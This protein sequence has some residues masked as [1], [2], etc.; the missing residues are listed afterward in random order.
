M[1]FIPLPFFLHSGTECPF[2]GFRNGTRQAF[3]RSRS[4]SVPESNATCQV[5]AT[6][7]GGDSY[8]TSLR[9]TILYHV[10]LCSTTLYFSALYYVCIYIYYI[11]HATGYYT[12]LYHVILR[13]VTLQYSI[14]YSKVKWCRT[15]L[16]QLMSS[17]SLPSSVLGGLQMSRCGLLGFRIASHQLCA[18]EFR[19]LGV[20]SPKL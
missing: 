10:M 4:K 15:L 16:F 3:C 5:K 8:V 17:L 9:C 6:V 1:L 19:R 2:L 13:H 14:T 20:A 7:S 11:H 18:A 12:V